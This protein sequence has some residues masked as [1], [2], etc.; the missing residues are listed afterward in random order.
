MKDLHTNLH[1]VF[2]CGSHFALDDCKS[3]N[4]LRNSMTHDVIMV[5][6]GNREHA[7]N[8]MSI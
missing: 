2:P 4:E 8:V 7:R 5:A 1:L 6:Y 3:V